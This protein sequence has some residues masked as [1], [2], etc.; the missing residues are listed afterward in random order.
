MNIY[1]YN[2]HFVPCSFGH[3]VNKLTLVRSVNGGLT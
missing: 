2:E 3:P 1:I